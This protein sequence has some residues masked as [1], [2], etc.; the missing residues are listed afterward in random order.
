MNDELGTIT[1]CYTI[2][3]DRTSKHPA[4]RLWRAF[5]EP[6]EISKWMDYPARVDLRPGGDYFIDFSRTHQGAL[7]GVIV[8]VEPER[9]FSYLWGWSLCEWTLEDMPGN[10]CRYRFVQ[11]GLADRGDGEEGLAAGWHE[12]FDRFD[13]HLDGRYIGEAEQKSRWEGLQ[14]RY[15]ERLD[16]VLVPR[17]RGPIVR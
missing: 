1:L 4:K 17:K 9:R 14:P 7:D 15:L 3:F 12:F 8:R 6:A 16:R 10:G 5:T 13:L 2:T 11:N